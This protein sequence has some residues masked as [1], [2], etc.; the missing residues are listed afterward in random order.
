MAAT[1]TTATTTAPTTSGATPRR[2]GRAP[3][4][5]GD[6]KAAPGNYGE[7]PLAGRPP[8]LLHGSTRL[9]R[10]R[11]RQRV[12]ACH[13]YVL[14]SGGFARPPPPQPLLVKPQPR[15]QKVFDVDDTASLKDIFASVE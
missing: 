9:D 5:T 13:P 4:A 6:G 11:H 8:S 1:T 14:D 12:A 7:T 3:S 10:L 2:T 15:I